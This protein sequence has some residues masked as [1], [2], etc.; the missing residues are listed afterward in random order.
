MPRSFAG[1]I[2]SVVAICTP[3]RDTAVVHMSA[4]K[5][6]SALVTGFAGRVGLNVARRFSNRSGARMTRG[7]RGGDAAMIQPRTG[8]RVRALVAGF[9][10]CVSHHMFGRLADRTSPVVAAGTASHH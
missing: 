1:R 2:G 8:E 4:C 3:D 9:A 6:H 7:A 5:S 10:R